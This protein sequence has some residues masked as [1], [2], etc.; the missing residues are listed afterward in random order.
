MS[1]MAHGT[2]SEHRDPIILGII[3]IAVG[4]G[5]F[6]VNAFPQAGGWIVAIVGLALLAVFAYTRLYAT[7][8]PGGIVTGLG[9]GI[10]ASELLTNYNDNGG[11]IVGG[12]GLGFIAIWVIGALFS[13]PEHHPWPLVPGGI[14]LTIGVLLALGDTTTQLLTYWPVVLIAIGLIVVVRAMISPSTPSTPESGPPDQV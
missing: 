5:G 8:I 1:S 2:R 3:L 10:V 13:I 14:L 9:L 7:L 4:V 6:A 12:L 11:L